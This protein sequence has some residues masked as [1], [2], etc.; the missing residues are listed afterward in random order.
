MRS[1]KVGDISGFEASS[2]PGRAKAVQEV[3]LAFEVPGQ[4]VELAVK[5]GDQVERGQLLARIDAR[6]YQAK[7]LAAQGA[8]DTARV[9]YERAEALVREEAL[10]TITRDERR[11]LMDVTKGQLDIA[12]KAVEDTRIFAPF[13]GTVSLTYVDNFQNVR[14][15]EPVIRLLDLSAVE[16]VVDIPEGQIGLAPYVKDVTVVFDAFPNRP[17]TARIRKIGGEASST[18]RTYP[19]TLTMDPPDDFEIKP[20]MAGR[21]TGNLEVPENLAHR[22]IEIPLSALFTPADEASQQSYVWVVSGDPATVHRRAVEPLRAHARGI[23]VSGLEPGERIV[24]AGV[25]SLREGQT[26]RLL[27][28]DDEARL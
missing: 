1:V 8:Y 12:R 3:D 20:G 14:A 10:A 17:L 7:L 28:D 21:A 25:N 2:Y 15:K 23:G 11:A 26:V 9:N 22:G 13:D 24:T 16:M 5:D 4:L 27:P 19:I 6:E 18:T